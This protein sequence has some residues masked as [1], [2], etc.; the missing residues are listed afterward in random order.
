MLHLQGTRTS[1]LS[2]RARLWTDGV[3]AYWPVGDY[4]VATWLSERGRSQVKI[5]AQ[6]AEE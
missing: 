3:I 4:A 5:R 1:L 2:N 6:I